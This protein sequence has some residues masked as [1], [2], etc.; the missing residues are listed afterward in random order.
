MESLKPLTQAKKNWSM[1]LILYQDI[2]YQD[3][4]EFPLLSGITFLFRDPIYVGV[5][6]YIYI[7]IHKY[8][9]KLRRVDSLPSH[10]LE[11]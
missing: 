8:K 6:I 4:Q 5:Y 11:I 10:S 1:Q 7:Y 3:K 9:Y 2:I